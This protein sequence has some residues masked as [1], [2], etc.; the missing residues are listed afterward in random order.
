MTDKNGYRWRRKLDYQPLFGK[1]S[2]SAGSFPEKQLVIEF[3]LGQN[4]EKIMS[5]QAY[6][7]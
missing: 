2:R 1:S 7:K 4:A 3:T 5:T 6:F